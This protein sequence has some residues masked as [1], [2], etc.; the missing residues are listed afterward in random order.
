M[1]YDGEWGTICDDEWDMKDARVVCR[2]LG[3]PGAVRSLQKGQISPGSGRIWLDD[4]D[5]TGGEQNIASCSHNLLGAHD[6][7]HSE[8]AGVECSMTGRHNMIRSAHKDNHQISLV[9]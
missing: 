9:F 6:C 3:Y 7:T 2:Q 4:V 1:F 8:D 5:C